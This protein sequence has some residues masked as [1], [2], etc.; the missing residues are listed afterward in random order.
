MKVSLELLPGERR[1]LLEEAAA[2]YDYLTESVHLSTTVAFCSVE[3]NI[4][5]RIRTSVPTVHWIGKL[6]V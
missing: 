6:P 5:S 2:Q 3:K 4:G 1:D